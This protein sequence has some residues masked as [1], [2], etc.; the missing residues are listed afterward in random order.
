LPLPR[1]HLLDELATAYVQVVAAGGGATI[2]V[3]RDYGVDGTLNYIEPIVAAQ[4]ERFAPSGFPVDFQLKG[5]TAAERRDDHIAYD[6]NVRNYDLIVTRLP[7]GTPFY[8]FLVCFDTDVSTWFAHK[9]N[10]LIL[11]AS[12]Y[13]WTQSGPPTTNTS[14][15]RIQI[16]VKNRLTSDAVEGMLH[17][18]KGRLDK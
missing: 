5:T 17:A 1:E 16:S 4:G 8:L 9:R 13:W 11:R 12:A 10:E 3:G 14:S 18:A 15:V 2:A 6:L 7:T